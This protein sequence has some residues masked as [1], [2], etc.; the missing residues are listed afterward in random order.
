VNWWAGWGPDLASHVAIVHEAGGRFSDLRGGL[1][2]DA[3]VHVVSNGALHDAVLRRVNV[4]IEE[5]RMDPTAEPT[6]DFDAI[7]KARAAPDL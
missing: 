7:F 2:I 4:V 1:D 5:A 3:R 6:E